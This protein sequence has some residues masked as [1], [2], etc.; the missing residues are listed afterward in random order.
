[1]L[2]KF[3]AFNVAF[4]F[5]IIDFNNIIIIIII[6]NTLINTTINI[7]LS[8]H[9]NAAFNMLLI[10]QQITSYILLTEN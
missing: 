2:I 5:F 6:D 7:L 8:D 9:L 3:S 4:F 1:M 10:I